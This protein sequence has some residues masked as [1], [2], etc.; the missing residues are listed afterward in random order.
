MFLNIGENIYFIIAS[1]IYLEM[2]RTKIHE[3]KQEETGYYIT[4]LKTILFV[5]FFEK[6]YKISKH[7]LIEINKN[8]QIFSLDMKQWIIKNCSE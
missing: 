3:S 7:N 6:Y 8:I 2:W 5:K 4:W 1:W